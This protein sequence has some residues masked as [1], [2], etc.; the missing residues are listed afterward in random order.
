MN[1]AIAI[2]L[3]AAVGSALLT[4]VGVWISRDSFDRMHFLAPSATIG[5][6]AVALAILL[7]ESISQIGV[8]SAI[9]AALLF[10]TNPILAHATARA[11]RVRRRGGIR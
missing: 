4:A 2:L 9:A 3:G 11:E 6:V 1:V 8:K 5:A 10:L 7:R